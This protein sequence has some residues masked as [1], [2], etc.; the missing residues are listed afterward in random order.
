MVVTLAPPRTSLW[1]DWL[2]YW[3]EVRGYGDNKSKLA[4]YL[5]IDRNT[6]SAWYTRGTRPSYANVIQTA[7][8]LKRPRTEALAAADYETET[9]GI[10]LPDE[11]KWVVTL[12]DH[13]LKVDPPLSPA[14]ARMV[15][16]QVRGL[17]QVREEKAPYEASPAAEPGPP[18]SPS[19]P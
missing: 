6:V 5:D 19:A 8:M 11:P 18:P 12:I 15:E 7:D 3:A 2:S 16:A 14:E 9:I 1:L 17:L 10:G 13:I 4:A